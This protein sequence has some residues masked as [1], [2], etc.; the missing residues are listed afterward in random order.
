M[1]SGGNV[2]IFQTN[3]LSSRKFQLSLKCQS[4]SNGLHGATTQKTAFFFFYLLKGPLFKALVQWG[5]EV[6]NPIVINQ[7]ILPPRDSGLANAGRL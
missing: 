6:S 4:I 3:W 5:R 2:A 7:S 1:Y